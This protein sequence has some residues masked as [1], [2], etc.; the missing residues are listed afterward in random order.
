MDP[1]ECL[2]CRIVRGDLPSHMV[3]EDEYTY[4]FLDIN[5]VSRGHT[6]VIPKNHAETLD[7]M[8]EEDAAAVFRTVRRLTETVENSLQPD[9]I[10]LL[11]NNGKAAGQE[12][13]HVHVHIIPRYGQDG[14]E[15][16]F[17]PGTLSDD[18]AAELRN[19]LQ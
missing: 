18:E 11:Q 4:A 2:F 8:T 9:G 3:Y 5:P 17:N 7:E 6:L 12:V 13:K 19:T 10:N 1:E 16:T 15:F 14:F